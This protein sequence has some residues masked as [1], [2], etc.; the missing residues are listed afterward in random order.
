MMI[1]LTLIVELT[2]LFLTDDCITYVNDGCITLRL[3]KFD[4]Q[5]CFHQVTPMLIG[6]CVILV[7]T[8][9]P[10]LIIQ[11]LIYIIPMKRP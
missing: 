1:W 4:Q 6:A 2:M 8:R 7:C 11:D 9:C 5:E 10:L 3:V